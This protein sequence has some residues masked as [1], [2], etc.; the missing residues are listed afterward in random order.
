MTDQSQ[1]TG[2][3]IYVIDMDAAQSSALRFEP[4]GQPVGRGIYLSKSDFIA[5]LL[6]EL[7]IS[8][9]LKPGE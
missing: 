8:G 7:I 9:G 6:R 3:I 2:G 5:A 1:V 4:E